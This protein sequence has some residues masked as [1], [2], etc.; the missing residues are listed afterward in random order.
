MNLTIVNQS[1][2]SSVIFVQ[3]SMNFHAS[4]QIAP[5]PQFFFCCSHPSLIYHQEI[6]TAGTPSENL[7]EKRS[8]NVN[9]AGAD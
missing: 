9:Q 7:S 5:L 3:P 8:R 2:N 4:K 6:R 1:V